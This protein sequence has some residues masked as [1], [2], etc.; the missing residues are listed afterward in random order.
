M[1]KIDLK[2]AKRLTDWRHGRGLDWGYAVPELAPEILR[3]VA[4]V[5][6][7]TPEVSP[8]ASFATRQQLGR[9]ATSD[10]EPLAS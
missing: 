4:A 8:S 7:A 3:E 2:E 10:A 9:T 5:E 1:E 6:E